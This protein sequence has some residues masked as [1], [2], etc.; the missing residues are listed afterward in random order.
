MNTDDKITVILDAIRREYVRA[1]A[2]YP[3]YHS[4]HEGAAV[5]REELAELWDCVKK[6]KRTDADGVMCIEALQVATT[7]MRFI[8]DLSDFEEFQA[9]L[10]GFERTR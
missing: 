7:A 3:A 2:A 5:I 6:S 1:D 10:S 9:T 8:L 4:G